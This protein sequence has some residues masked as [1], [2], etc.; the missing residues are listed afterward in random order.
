M[1]DRREDD[2]K[3][4]IDDDF[5]NYRISCLNCGERSFE[6]KTINLDIRGKTVQG[7]A[8]VCLNCKEPLMDSFQMNELLK[9]RFK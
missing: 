5:K 7:T 4:K 8:W 1:Q 3:E 9:S 2:E 6:A